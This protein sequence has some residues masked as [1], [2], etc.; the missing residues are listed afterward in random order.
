MNRA[1]GQ[2]QRAGARQLLDGSDARTGPRRTPFL[3][4]RLDLPGPVLFSFFYKF[5]CS[6]GSR[7]TSTHT[8][9]PARAGV[10]RAIDRDEQK[11]SADGA[12]QQ[13]EPGTG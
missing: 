3:L 2:T 6:G 4:G 5:A 1:T 7:W 8:A 11:R 13:S 9:G 10:Q 12:A